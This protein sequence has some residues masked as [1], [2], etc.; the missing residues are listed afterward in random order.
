[1]G[2]E[3]GL[4]WGF[5]VKMVRSWSENVS[6]FRNWFQMKNMFTTSNVAN[7]LVLAKKPKC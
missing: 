1:M 5:G 3:L 2:P 6:E 7:L 4:K